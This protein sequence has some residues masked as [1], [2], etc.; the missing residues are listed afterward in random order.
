MA[1]SGRFGKGL[2]ASLDWEFK[3]I[4]PVTRRECRGSPVW[5]ESGR[6]DIYLLKPY[7]NVSHCM[8]STPDAFM[9]PVHVATLIPPNMARQHD[10]A[11]KAFG[12]NES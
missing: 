5:E 12:K 2:E 1:G 7:V 11:K 9:L 8:A 6:Y 10:H 3:F 4:C